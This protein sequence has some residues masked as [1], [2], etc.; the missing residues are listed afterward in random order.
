[1]YYITGMICV[2]GAFFLSYLE[3][4]L[5]FTKLD[6]SIVF[7][8]LGQEQF[9]LA[10]NDFDKH[11]ISLLKKESDVVLQLKGL[12]CQQSI[13][14][15]YFRL[16]KI[17]FIVQNSIKIDPNSRIVLFSIRKNITS[18][19]SKFNIENLLQIIEST[20]Y[21]PFKMILWV[22][23]R[24][25]KQ[26]G[27]AT[28]VVPYMNFSFIDRMNQENYKDLFGKFVSVTIEIKFD[29]FNKKST[30][31]FSGDLESG[32]KFLEIRKIH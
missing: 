22:S 18:F 17:P 9:Q 14:K 5:L 20:G 21:Q 23:G 12:L 2:L 6:S 11:A 15:L 25:L 29:S 27:K 24:V 19:E 13:E 30:L 10:I 3:R 31:S 32:V 26:K 4:D 28:V 7:E 16:G 1:M 8:I